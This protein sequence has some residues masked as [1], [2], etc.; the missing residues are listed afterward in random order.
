[1]VAV[2]VLSTCPFGQYAPA[3][4]II[5]AGFVHLANI[6]PTV[7]QDI[8]YAS[9]HNFVG[10]PVAGYNTGEC[11]LTNPAAQA[12]VKVQTELKS[13]MLSLIVWDCYRPARAVADFL[14]WSKSPS[15]TAIPRVVISS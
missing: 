7:R 12:L 4:E 2:F 9:S 3:A 10:R 11:L 15:G 14:Q 8:R 1:M 13:K 5:K 6:D